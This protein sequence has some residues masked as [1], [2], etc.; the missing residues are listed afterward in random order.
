LKKT[1]TS[2]GILR[3]KK[4]RAHLIRKKV[5]IILESGL[6]RNMINSYKVFSLMAKIGTKSK[7]QLEQGPVLRQD[8]MLKSFSEKCRSRGT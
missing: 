5:S 2:V 3:D 8:L 7:N 4:W 1:K 6:M